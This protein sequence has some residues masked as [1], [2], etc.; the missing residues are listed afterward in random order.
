MP[1]NEPG[2]MVSLD[3][4]LVNMVVVIRHKQQF[5]SMQTYT[6]PLISIYMVITFKHRVD[7]TQLPNTPIARKNFLRLYLRTNRVLL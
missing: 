5:K 4:S 6:K 1:K 7:G 2:I 3:H